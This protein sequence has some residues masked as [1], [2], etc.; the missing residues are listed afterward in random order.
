MPNGE[1]LYDIGSAAMRWE[2]MWADQVYGRSVYVDNYIYHNGD[3]DTYIT[4]GICFLL[5]SEIKN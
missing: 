5:F 4:F 1:H 3:A 2:D